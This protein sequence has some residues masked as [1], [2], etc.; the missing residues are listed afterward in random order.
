MT[1]SRKFYLA[2]HFHKTCK[3]FFL[4][5]IFR[6]CKFSKGVRGFITEKMCSCVEIISIISQLLLF[7]LFFLFVCFVSESPVFVIQALFSIGLVFLSCEI[8]QIFFFPMPHKVDSQHSYFKLKLNSSCLSK[9]II[10][11]NSQ[12][13]ET[14]GWQATV[15]Y[16]SG[17]GLI[18]RCHLG[19]LISA[20]PTWPRFMPLILQQWSNWVRDYI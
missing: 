2:I 10:V 15:L 3:T 14:M 18:R 12:K 20:H 1:V 17:A 19:V 6:Y 16:L 4:C 8:T 7:H 5:N 11:F 9:S 13:A